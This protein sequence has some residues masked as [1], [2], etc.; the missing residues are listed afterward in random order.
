MSV[1]TYERSSTLSVHPQKL[2]CP[3]DSSMATNGSPTQPAAALPVLT[4]QAHVGW[5]W[6]ARNMLLQSCNIQLLN[7]CNSTKTK[8][9][10]AAQFWFWGKVFLFSWWEGGSAAA[11]WA[12]HRVE[13]IDEVAQRYSHL[14]EQIIPLAQV[15]S[16]TSIPSHNYKCNLWNKTIL[17]QY[18]PQIH[19]LYC[20]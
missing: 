1:L 16:A 10:C 4:I 20:N 8:Y 18:I 2:G 19:D 6:A 3:E 5:V 15:T 12:L 11:H 17:S 9:L 13:N 14:Q 7:K